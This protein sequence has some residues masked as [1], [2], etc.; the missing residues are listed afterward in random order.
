MAIY[1][2]ALRPLILPVCLATDPASASF[3]TVE[4]MATVMDKLRAAVLLGD[5]SDARFWSPLGPLG[6]VG[7][8]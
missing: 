8:T 4:L 2:P 6:C 7:V 5:A 1:R 3:I